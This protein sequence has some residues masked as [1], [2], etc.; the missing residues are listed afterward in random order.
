MLKVSK[1]EEAI[2]LEDDVARKEGDG[3]E[4]S[5]EDDII[6]IGGIARMERM[7]VREIQPTR[8]LRRNLSPLARRGI[9][10]QSLLPW[11]H[12]PLLHPPLVTLLP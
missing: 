5:G 11:Y 3:K 12:L 4:T 8:G 10:D 6:T 1:V 9:Q 2:G 7:A